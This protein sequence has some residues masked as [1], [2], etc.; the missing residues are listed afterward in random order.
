MLNHNFFL[1]NEKLTLERTLAE[2]RINK[3]RRENSE[4]RV[5]IC[6]SGYFIWPQS[7]YSNTVWSWSQGE[8][9]ESHLVLAVK[10]R[11][12]TKV[13]LNSVVIHFTVSSTFCLSL[14]HLLFIPH[15]EASCWKSWRTLTLKVTKLLR[16]S[17][18][19]NMLVTVW[20][21]GL[22]VQWW[23]SVVC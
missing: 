12:L 4:L 17:F 2:D 23:W 7:S 20:K 6:V 21:N 16:Y 11:D 5:R 10:D 13:I 18:V 3:L 14:W 1:Q 19:E 22:T 9:E 8:L 15:R